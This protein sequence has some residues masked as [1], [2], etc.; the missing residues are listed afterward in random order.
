MNAVPVA[1]RGGCLAGCRIACFAMCA[2][3]KSG[4][5]A[6]GRRVLGWLRRKR[7]SEAGRRRVV[8][9]LA[10]AE[11]DLIEVHVR[12]ALDLFDAVG[13]EMPFDRA[14]ELYLDTMDVTE[15]RASIVARRVMARLESAPERRGRRRD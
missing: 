2:K 7:L 13:E 4:S 10:R 5:N 12:N 3:C 6:G 8:I 14:L 1:G 11:E 9:A 15:P